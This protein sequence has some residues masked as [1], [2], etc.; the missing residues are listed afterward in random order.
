MMDILGKITFSEVLLLFVL[1]FVLPGMTYLVLRLRKYEALFGFLPDDKAKKKAKKSEPVT[2]ESAAETESVPDVP[3]DVYPYRSKVFLSPADKAC[4]GAMREALGE[5]VEVF[6][7]VALWELVES[8]EKEAG[9]LQRLH[10]K[11]VDFLVCDRKTGRPL[12]AVAYN[13][14]KGRPAGPVDE[15]KKI[16]DAAE[17]NIVF[18]DMAEEYDVKSLKDALGI[19]ELDI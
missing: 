12:T 8:T 4:L 1:L 13:P 2:V 3:N 18:I 15:L 16:C 6:P 19:P 17:A 14:G 10:G 11:D 9:Y 7:K 5:E